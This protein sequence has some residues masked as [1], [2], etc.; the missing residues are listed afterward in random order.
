MTRRKPRK[1]RLFRVFFRIIL[2]ASLVFAVFRLGDVIRDSEVHIPEIVN[3]IIKQQGKITIKN[4]DIDNEMPIKGSKFSITSV[5]T[6]ELVDT[7]IT[8]QNGEAS[9]VL[10]DY[11]SVY[12]IRLIEQNPY[13]EISEENAF[14][15]EINQ[16]NHQVIIE[17][18]MK[19]HIKH[20]L[21]AENGDI[22]IDEV[23][24]DVPTVMQNPE[25]PNG[26]E[27][28]S[29]TAVLN[30]K[31]YDVEKTKMADEYLPK[32]AFYVK[33]GKLYGANP[34]VS[35][36]GNPREKNGFF[37]YAPPI[38]EAANLYLDSVEGEEKP[39]DI[40]GSTRD[41]IIE[42]LNQGIPVVIWVTL[43]L[44][45]PK[46]NYSWY[47][48]DTGE[49]KD[50]PINLHCVVLNG[51][52]GDNVHVMNPLKGQVVYNADAFFQSYLELGSHAMIL[53]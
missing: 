49:K 5:E 45:K 29:L 19:G 23:Y 46:L 32:E 33:D 3:Q 10:L 9:S 44:S 17:S 40:S 36:A 22:V 25:L 30:Y 52:A 2:L 47:L 20:A 50:M 16:E 6:G 35:Y 28:T 48:M 51:Y 11:D 7:L 53:K 39:I 34:Y 18:K 37:S 14:A 15:I 38:V 21:R 31:G 24:I 4:I 43:D 41:E 26:C 1:L 27:I 42:Y 12:E 8:D 13:Y